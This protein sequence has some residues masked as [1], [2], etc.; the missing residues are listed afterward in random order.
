MLIAFEGI[1][2]SGKTAISSKL[3]DNISAIWTKEPMFD[4]EEADRLNETPILGAH[5]EALFFM[6]RVQHQTFLRGVR[7]DAIVCDRY[8]WSALVYGYVFSPDTYEFIRTAYSQPY[9]MVPDCFVFV[10]TPAEVC[11]KRRPS[12][13][14]D[15]EKTLKSLRTL[16]Q[17]YKDIHPF[18]IPEWKNVPVISV[19]GTGNVDVAV[20]RVTAELRQRWPNIV[21]D[22]EQTEMFVSGVETDDQTI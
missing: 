5:R 4:S 11:A 10:D 2:G 16:E 7:Q 8:L 13:S 21:V 1:D 20:A 22:S 9:F 19:S 15:V 18:R 14:V 3:A 12:R 6:D 17:A